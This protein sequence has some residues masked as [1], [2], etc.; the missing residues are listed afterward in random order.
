M[1]ASAEVDSSE[2]VASADVVVDVAEVDDSD[3]ES[4][5]L[6]QPAATPIISAATAKLVA[7]ERAIS[8]EF[9]SEAETAKTDRRI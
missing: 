3:A 9:L 5:D 1:L 2:V 4:S 6:L 8:M 7:D